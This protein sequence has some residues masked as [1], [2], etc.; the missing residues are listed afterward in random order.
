MHL[1][2]QFYNFLEIVVAQNLNWTRP[3]FFYFMEQV[4]YL[5]L[6]TAELPL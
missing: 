4:S 6:G 2:G 5:S 3:L 1:C